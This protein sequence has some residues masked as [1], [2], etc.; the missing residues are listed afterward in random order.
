M[1]DFDDIVT[2]IKYNDDFY[3][4]FMEQRQALRRSNPEGYDI[5]APGCYA[6]QQLPPEERAT[7][8]YRLF[9]AYF[10]QIHEE[11]QRASLDQAAA[12]PAKTYLGPDDESLLYESLSYA[13]RDSQGPDKVATV[14]AD[15]LAN[16]LA[17]VEL[18]RHRVAMRDAKREGGAR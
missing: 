8:L 1:S 11:E 14:L 3:A 16:V 17:E 15:S 12:D 6:W 2:E 9:R 7:A 10:W 4:A 13:E 18:L 5:T